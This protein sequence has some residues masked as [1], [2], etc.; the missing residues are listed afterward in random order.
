M[1][2]PASCRGLLRGLLLFGLFGLFILQTGSMAEAADEDLQP[3]FGRWQGTAISDQ[4]SAEGEFSFK[5]RDLDVEIGPK[6]TGF[7][8]TWTAELRDDSGFL[9]RRSSSLEFIPVG[10]GVYE[11]VNPPEA[12]LSYARTWARISDDA[13]VVYVFE[14]DE[15]GLYEVSRYVRRLTSLDVMELGYTRERDGR[16]ARTIVGRLTR[17]KS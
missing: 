12:G 16:P 2:C 6:G 14:V 4:V 9:S 11:A 10:Q 3:Y 5:N 15:S 13:F 8:I 17:V 1:D 7:A